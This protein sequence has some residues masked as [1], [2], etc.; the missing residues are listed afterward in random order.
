MPDA[1]YHPYRR[2]LTTA[3]MQVNANWLKNYLLPRGWTLNAIAACLGNWQSECTLNPNRPQRAGYPQD[4]KGGFGLAQWTS[5]GRK[6]GS[7]CKS[8]NIYNIARD[9]N[10]AGRMEPQIAY[11][12][13]EC[14]NGINGGKTW[15]ASHGYNYSWEQFK[16]SNDHPATLATAY[17]WQYERSAANNPGS[18]PSNA[19][20]WY[21]YLIGQPY[22]P[23]S[24]ATY[25]ERPQFMQSSLIGGWNLQFLIM[26]ILL[27]LM[28]GNRK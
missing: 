4:T 26:I 25:A 5:W 24:S 8:Q 7:W 12:D 15:F 22:N 13:W 6:Y 23:I 18:R 19:V 11:H 28:G 16:R 3:Q 17:Y 27:L 9:D 21:N 10:P 14:T 2:A 20:T 1:Y